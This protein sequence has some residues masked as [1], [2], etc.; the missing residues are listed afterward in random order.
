MRALVVYESMFGNTRLVAQVAADALAAAG[1]AVTLTEVSDAPAD[2]GDVDLLVVGG[3]THAFGMSRASTRAD[4]ANQAG[5]RPVASR[6]IGIREWLDRLAAPASTVRVAT[7]DTRVR[8]P[9]VPGSAARAAD[10][11]LRHLGLLV[12]APATSFWVAG[13][14]GPLHDGEL[15]RVRE[16]ATGLVSTAAPVAGRR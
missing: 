1:A 14:K 16:W 11:R 8:P 9:R 13:T 3:P 2:V 15:D 4:A 10:R 7:F 6:G 5:S 12:V